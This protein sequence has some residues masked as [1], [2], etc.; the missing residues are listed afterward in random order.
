M[1]Y[2]VEIGRGREELSALMARVREWLDARR[3]EPDV[4]RCAID[5]ESVTCRVEFKFEREALACA[6]AFGGKVEPLGNNPVR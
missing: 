2:V 4:F 1:L 6:E 5:A 3:F